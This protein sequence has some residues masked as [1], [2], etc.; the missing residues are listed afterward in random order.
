MNPKRFVIEKDG[1]FIT[2][3]S[4]NDALGVA[5]GLFGPMPKAT[6]FRKD[7][8]TTIINNNIIVTEYSY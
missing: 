1:K 2:I 8:K 3:N 6:Y 7:N 4:C 5:R